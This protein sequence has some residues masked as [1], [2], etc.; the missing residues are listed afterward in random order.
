MSSAS[1][2]PTRGD[3]SSSSGPGTRSRS[4]V[5]RGGDKDKGS[6]RDRAALSLREL[7]M[8]GSQSTRASSV[9]GLAP[10]VSGDMPSNEML[11]DS[12]ELQ[13]ERATK[14]YTS[15]ME[16]YAKKDYA[17]ALD[18]FIR[19]LDFPFMKQA[20]VVMNVLQFVATPQIASQKEYINVIM[21]METEVRSEE[22]RVRNLL[23]T[24]SKALD[25][26]QKLIDVQTSLEGTVLM[27]STAASECSMQTS[28]DDGWSPRLMS[29]K[30]SI[31]GAALT[32]SSAQ[33]SELASMEKKIGGVAALT[34]MQA[35][36][37]FLILR[38]RGL[39]LGAW[40]KQIADEYSALWRD[41]LSPALRSSSSPRHN[42]LV[43]II[44]TCV[45]AL[46]I[47]VHSRLH[48]SSLHSLSMA[49]RVS[50][51]AGLGLSDS[52]LF[53]QAA[54]A[55]FLLATQPPLPTY[56]PSACDIH[57]T[58]LR[59]AIEAVPRTQPLQARTASDALETARELLELARG[60][61]GNHPGIIK[62]LLHVLVLCGDLVAARNL[63]SE[64]LRLEADVDSGRSYFASV[65]AARARA[66]LAKFSKSTSP[67][68]TPLSTEAQKELVILEDLLRR[69]QTKLKA[70]N[71][72]EDRGVEPWCDEA[73]FLTRDEH[74][75]TKLPRLWYVST[76][77]TPRMA[78]LVLS[79]HDVG[80]FSK[81]LQERS[82]TDES[83][84]PCVHA[85]STPRP[86]IIDDHALVDQLSPDQFDD[87]ECQPSEHIKARHCTLNECF[88][89]SG[90]SLIDLLMILHDLSNNAW[91]LQPS[92]P[93]HP[94]KRR[95]ANKPALS[96]QI[97]Q[98][99]RLAFERVELPYGLPSPLSVDQ[100]T[101]K[102]A[103]NHKRILWAARRS[104]TLG[105]TSTG[106]FP[107][108]CALGTSKQGKLR[109]RAHLAWLPLFTFA[110][111]SCLL[112]DDPESTEGVSMEDV[113][114]MADVN[115]QD[116][117]AQVHN[118]ED[119]ESGEAMQPDAAK[120][121]DLTT[122]E[123]SL[124]GA[125]AAMSRRSERR[126]VKIDVDTESSED[127]DGTDD[128]EAEEDAKAN[129]ST[130]ESLEAQIAKEIKSTFGHAYFG[131]L[132]SRLEDVTPNDTLPQWLGKL[133]A[134]AA[135]REHNSEQEGSHALLNES[136]AIDAIALD[137]SVDASTAA[138]TASVRDAEIQVP[139]LVCRD[140]Y[141]SQEVSLRVTLEGQNRDSVPNPVMGMTIMV[142]DSIPEHSIQQ[143]ASPT[144]PL[145]EFDAEVQSLLD[146]VHAAKE[147]VQT[148]FLMRHPLLGFP[149]VA[150]NQFL[151]APLGLTPQADPGPFARSLV[152]S[153]LHHRS[154]L[155]PTARY[156]DLGV[157]TYMMTAFKLPPSEGPTDSSNQSEV[158]APNSPGFAPLDTLGPMDSRGYV[159]LYGV[160]SAGLGFTFEAYQKLI[161]INDTTLTPGVANDLLE[162]G[163]DDI[164]CTA[165]Q[166]TSSQA[167][168]NSMIS[169]DWHA[170]DG[171]P[172]RLAIARSTHGD[173]AWSWSDVVRQSVAIV[174][175]RWL[176][177]LGQMGGVMNFYT[178]E[179]TTALQVLSGTLYPN[180]TDENA[181]AME[182]EV[183]PLFLPSSIIAAG[184]ALNAVLDIFL[185]G[186]QH[187]QLNLTEESSTEQSSLITCSDWAGFGV[188]DS[189]PSPPKAQSYAFINIW[190]AHAL[191]TLAIH[192]A[193]ASVTFKRM[194][195]AERR[196]ATELHGA[197]SNTREPGSVEPHGTLADPAI[198]SLQ[199]ALG[200]A[201]AYNRDMD[202]GPI[203]LS[204]NS[205]TVN[206]DQR[207]HETWRT[208]ATQCYNL[209]T[210][211]S[212]I[213]A[214]LK[215][216]AEFIPKQSKRAVDLLI[217]RLDSCVQL[218]ELPTMLSI[219]R[220]SC[221]D[222][223]NTVRSC[224]QKP[225]FSSWFEYLELMSSQ[226]GLKAENYLSREALRLT[227]GIVSDQLRSD[228]ET[229]IGARVV[230]SDGSRLQ[231][232]GSDDV[233][234]RF[235]KTL[236]MAVTKL[237]LD[238]QGI[239]DRYASHELQDQLVP[240]LQ[241]QCKELQAELDAWS[242]QKLL[243]HLLSTFETQMSA[244]D[245]TP[246]KTHF[247]ELLENAATIAK[248]ALPA[249]ARLQIRYGEDRVSLY[250]CESGTV[251]QSSYFIQLLRALELCSPG[252]ST[253]TDSAE[254]QVR[255]ESWESPNKFVSQAFYR[256][257]A[258][259]LMLFSDL[260]G[261]LAAL[262]ASELAAS[263]PQ[264]SLFIQSASPLYGFDPSAV[265]SA[266]QASLP[267]LALRAR[268]LAILM[269]LRDLNLA[270]DTCDSSRLRRYWSALSRAEELLKRLHQDAF[271]D[272]DLLGLNS[273]I[274]ELAKCHTQASTILH[275][276][277]SRECS[278]HDRLVSTLLAL[279]SDVSYLEGACAS[280]KQHQLSDRSQ[281]DKFWYRLIDLGLGA[282]AVLVTL[283]W[284][285]D[286]AILGYVVA[287]LKSLH[288]VYTQL[289]H[290]LRRSTP[291]SLERARD[292]IASSVF[293]DALKAAM[294][295]HRR[296]EHVANRLA[297]GV[298]SH[299]VQAIM[300]LRMA[301][302]KRLGGQNDVLQSWTRLWQPLIF[303]TTH[304]LFND[305]DYQYG[306]PFMLSRVRA[307]FI[308]TDHVAHLPFA[309][310][311]L[312][313][314]ID[315]V[316]HSMGDTLL[317]EVLERFLPRKL[318][319]QRAT[320]E[321]LEFVEECKQFMLTQPSLFSI[322]RMP[323]M[324]LSLPDAAYSYFADATCLMLTLMFDEHRQLRSN[325]PFSLI[326]DATFFLS[327]LVPRSGLA[328][329]F[330]LTIQRSAWMSKSLGPYPWTLHE[331]FPYVH[332]TQS[333]YL[334]A[335]ILRRTL[336]LLYGTC[337]E[338][339]PHELCDLLRGGLSDPQL[340]NMSIEDAMSR[341]EPTWDVSKCETVIDALQ[342][343]LHIK[344]GT[345][346]SF[347]KLLS[348]V[349]A[350]ACTESHCTWRA[351]GMSCY[352]AGCDHTDD[353]VTPP[354]LKLFLSEN[355]PEVIQSNPS[356]DDAA[357]HS[358][359]LNLFIHKRDAFQPYFDDSEY[360]ENVVLPC[361]LSEALGMS[362]TNCSEQE[363]LEPFFN[364][365]QYAHYGLDTQHVARF[366][367]QNCLAF[368]MGLFEERVDC[369]TESLTRSALYAVSPQVMGWISVLRDKRTEEFDECI[370]EH[371]PEAAPHT[372]GNDG[373]FPRGTFESVFQY[374]VTIM[375]NPA[376]PRLLK[377]FSEDLGDAI[378]SVFIPAFVKHAFEN[379]EGKS[380]AE[381]AL[382]PDVPELYACSDK[383]NEMSDVLRDSYEEDVISHRTYCRYFETLKDVL[384]GDGENMVRLF[385]RFPPDAKP[386]SLRN[387]LS[388]VS[389]LTTFEAL[390]QDYSRPYIAEIP[391]FDSVSPVGSG[392]A[393]KI[394]DGGFDLCSSLLTY[395]RSPEAENDVSGEIVSRSSIVWAQAHSLDHLIA[396]NYE[397]L[398]HIP[399]DD[400]GET[401]VRCGVFYA[402]S[403][404]PSLVSKR[405]LKLMQGTINVNVH[406]YRR[407][408]SFQ[409]EDQTENV[410]QRVQETVQRF[411]LNRTSSSPMTLRAIHQVLADLA[412]AEQQD[413]SLVQQERLRSLTSRLLYMSLTG[414]PQ[415]VPLRL[416]LP[417]SATRTAKHE[418]MFLVGAGLNSE[419]NP[420]ATIP[421]GF[422]NVIADMRDRVYQ[423]FTILSPSR[424]LVYAWDQ[425][426]LSPA[427]FVWPPTRVLNLLRMLIPETGTD[428]FASFQL[429][430]AAA[431]HMK[432]GFSSSFAP[433]LPGS[434]HVYLRK[435]ERDAGVEEIDKLEKNL[436]EIFSAAYRLEAR[437]MSHFPERTLFDLSLLVAQIA[438]VSSHVASVLSPLPRLS[439]T[440]TQLLSLQRLTRRSVKTSSPPIYLPAGFL[441]VHRPD[442]AQ[443]GSGRTPNALLNVITE[444]LTWPELTV[445]RAL[446]QTRDFGTAAVSIVP[447]FH[448]GDSL[449]P[450]HG[451][452]LNLA[453]AAL[454]K[455]AQDPNLDHSTNSGQ[456][457]KLPVL[458]ITS[459]QVVLR[460]IDATPSLTG[461]AAQGKPLEV[462]R[463]AIFSELW[464]LILQ[465]EELLKRQWYDPGKVKEATLKRVR[466]RAGYITSVATLLVPLT[467]LSRYL[468][469]LL[470]HADFL[471][472]VDTLED[473]D[474][475]ILL[476]YPF[477][478]DAPL[479]VHNPTNTQI[480]FEIMDFG[481]TNGLASEPFA[482]PA[483]RAL[484]TWQAA[485][486][487]LS[488]YI[489]ARDCYRASLLLSD[490]QTT[491]SYGLTDTALS[492]LKNRIIQNWSMLL[493]RARFLFTSTPE[494]CIPVYKPQREVMP[495]A[496][497]VSQPTD[498]LG[499][500]KAVVYVTE[501]REGALSLVESMSSED[502]TNLLTQLH[503][504][505]LASGAWNCQGASIRDLCA[506]PLGERLD[507][508]GPHPFKQF[509]A[510][511][512]E[513]L[514]DTGRMSI[515]SK[516]NVVPITLDAIKFVGH[517]I[518]NGWVGTDAAGASV[519]CPLGDF[520]QAISQQDL[521][522]LLVRDEALVTNESDSDLSSES[523]LHLKDSTAPTA[524]I[525]LL[526]A[527]AELELA[528]LV[529][530]RA[531]QTLEE[532]QW[533]FMQ[534][535]ARTIFGTSMSLGQ[536]LCSA[537]EALAEIR[538][539][540]NDTSRVHGFRNRINCATASFWQ[541]IQ[542]ALSLT[543][544]SLRI[545]LSEFYGSGPDLPSID[546][547]NAN[548]WLLNELIV[549]MQALGLG[550][551]SS[552]VCAMP[553]IDQLVRN[554]RASRGREQDI[555]RVRKICRGIF[556]GTVL[557]LEIRLWLMQMASRLTAAL[558]R[559]MSED[560]TDLP[561]MEVTSRATDII[562]GMRYGDLITEPSRPSGVPDSQVWTYPPLMMYGEYANLISTPG[563]AATEKERSVALITSSV[564][565]QEELEDRPDQTQIT[566]LPIYIQELVTSLTL[567]GTTIDAL[568]S[569]MLASNESPIKP[570]SLAFSKWIPRCSS[571]DPGDEVRFGSLLMIP[572]MHL[573]FARTLGQILA[574]TA[575]APH[576]GTTWIAC[577]KHVR[578]AA[579]RLLA[580][581]HGHALASL[582]YQQQLVMSQATGL[583]VFSN[584]LTNKSIEDQHQRAILAACGLLKD[585]W[586][587]GTM[588]QVKSE[589]ANLSPTETLPELSS[590]L[591][592]IDSSLKPFRGFVTNPS[593]KPA[594]HCAYGECANHFVMQVEKAAELMKSARQ[595]TQHVEAADAQ[596]LER[597]R[598]SVPS[599]M[600]LQTE[601]LINALLTVV[602][603]DIPKGGPTVDD[604]LKDLPYL[605]PA[606]A[607][608]K[609]SHNILWATQVLFDLIQAWMH[610]GLLGTSLG[611]LKDC[612]WP[613]FAP[614]KAKRTLFAVRSN[615]SP[616]ILRFIEMRAAMFIRGC[617]SLLRCLRDQ[618]DFAAIYEQVAPE[619]AVEVTRD[620][621]APHSAQAQ[622][623]DPPSTGD[624]VQQPDSALMQDTS[625]DPPP[626]K[627]RPQLVRIEPC[628]IA[629][630]LDPEGESIAAW[631]SVL[632]FDAVGC[633]LIREEA[634]QKSIMED[635][636]DA[637]KKL[638]KRIKKLSAQRLRRMGEK[639]PRKTGQTQLSDEASIWG[640]DSL[641][642]SKYPGPGLA[643]SEHL[644]HQQ[645]VDTLGTRP[646]FRERFQLRS[647]SGPRTS[648]LLPMSVNSRFQ[649]AHW[650]PH[651]LQ[652]VL[653]VRA[654]SLL[655]QV[656]MHVQGPDCGSCLAEHESTI[657]NSEAQSTEQELVVTD[658]DPPKTALRNVLEQ[659][660]DQYLALTQDLRLFESKHTIWRRIYQ[661]LP[662]YGTTCVNE[663]K[664]S[665]EPNSVSTDRMD[666]IQPTHLTPLTSPVP[667]ATISD[668]ESVDTRAD[669]DEG[670][671]AASATKPDEAESGVQLG[672]RRRRRPMKKDEDASD[673]RK[674]VCIANMPV[675]DLS[676]E[677]G[678]QPLDAE[679]GA[680][681]EQALS[682]SCVPPVVSL[683]IEIA[684][685]AC[686]IDWL[687]N[688]WR[689]SS[690]GGVQH[691]FDDE[692]R[693]RLV[694][695]VLVPLLQSLNMSAIEFLP[696]PD[697]LKELYLERCDS[698]DE[699]II[700]EEVLAL[701]PI[702]QLTFVGSLLNAKQPRS[703]KEMVRLLV[704]C[705][706]TT[707]RTSPS[708]TDLTEITSQNSLRMTLRDVC[709]ATGTYLKSNLSPSFNTG[710][711]ILT[712]ILARI[713]SDSDEQ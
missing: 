265:P 408:R 52:T 190:A 341:L 126:S 365:T 449:V 650:L 667:N 516:Y 668:E 658:S 41:V 378:K 65:S 489:S 304:L 381:F 158:V 148:H 412:H 313:K 379:T 321:T 337:V 292:V 114:V 266:C 223:P 651:L 586:A 136:E 393:A 687:A 396:I 619:E 171:S 260:M 235:V 63:A 325:S 593:T 403:A 369:D 21:A 352:L 271:H 697:A 94:R 541:L 526:D 115:G 272:I 422:S 575:G 649:V 662:I 375:D 659:S 285:G 674:R 655:A 373:N 122:A 466:K 317:D 243:G 299:I 90:V 646:D 488:R 561:P 343:L 546:I 194:I 533:V 391:R 577:S 60:I 535:Q 621:T 351:E 440:T 128:N 89:G 36:L 413:V 207:T 139:F 270:V 68:R 627:A 251:T 600:V 307:D 176:E 305:Y 245:F 584:D 637:R 244:E 62:M 404:I 316:G 81:F 361:G 267:R 77:H 287:R 571:D 681:N 30:S 239:A 594:L 45:Q 450:V 463:Q 355:F 362:L 33:A 95:S 349:P 363:V 423:K 401:Y 178:S 465:M 44:L 620:S 479:Q 709:L 435:L 61:D 229:T 130:G 169:I 519:A 146:P 205:P 661:W 84:R 159:H 366:V 468:L 609:N 703:L 208:L 487:L 425:P 690:A 109:K 174:A 360:S 354:R 196:Q 100:S 291:S 452:R 591:D 376:E 42:M 480:L 135:F 143:L 503:A 133:F 118:A 673:V 565:H 215:K 464:D 230:A 595:G 441:D 309:A 134:P 161:L 511:G 553:N 590:I 221:L 444:A 536:S 295:K 601:E 707:P 699:R 589:A 680:Y 675:I 368:R 206:A 154:S 695:Y 103:W 542:R 26:V 249:L 654:L 234:E 323:G 294:P 443:Y 608:W 263:Q 491:K 195:L 523:A 155:M 657:A 10:G 124:G 562:V 105:L 247:G 485:T 545:L 474:S 648:V 6:G 240:T 686:T 12:T 259:V 628:E 682:E 47:D 66:V 671:I 144:Q 592:E 46:L 200:D 567:T 238:V 28:V 86:R 191:R 377:N 407:P 331:V 131:K 67:S 132:K 371:A 189:L 275:N 706:T 192:I 39:V 172:L 197:P 201:F 5:Q 394:A 558:A 446:Q 626:Q 693:L 101:A 85:Q 358:L 326:R 254:M 642:P 110:G 617:A 298:L 382:L 96:L 672:Q 212:Y 611:P 106:L 529:W 525:P 237:T 327:L 43:R 29:R 504:L 711:K 256:M 184:L 233:A 500:E 289:Y 712:S 311:F 182:V 398:S 570:G 202:I 696:I 23:D 663:R 80:P 598:Y 390:L 219:Q 689:T 473:P 17:V 276:L 576:S 684:R 566:V 645:L 397:A 107:I 185:Q 225:W 456:G 79:P 470:A 199:S 217:A 228:T 277:I 664:L 177:D 605:S 632:L 181:K 530:G 478:G 40:A 162:A 439:A 640:M 692:S 188:L 710:A 556:A 498:E 585:A 324:R 92:S 560:W 204:L 616:V 606:E 636:N 334:S 428:K 451:L 676:E 386:P 419:V 167:E 421:R 153:A 374:V 447:L 123:E 574:L 534:E 506:I 119:G 180:D 102:L 494:L 683:Q 656:A 455:L 427:S 336:K 384:Y 255:V 78:Y 72:V 623:T 2:D 634:R 653:S 569:H 353:A 669:E 395:Q 596:V 385:Y 55:A 116:S 434:V 517:S 549:E 57:L 660:K 198:A 416:S 49:I 430:F 93:T 164:S 551:A 472:L 282:S 142:E 58:T 64:I 16:A 91:I 538:A 547:A 165:Q 540:A 216:L 417:T 11:A 193:H 678:E 214:R 187:H 279:R 141:P 35:R 372:L 210:S 4:P 34:N 457:F 344:T 342:L 83:E 314:Q 120:I 688:Q 476:R 32:T 300:R 163:V 329:Y 330:P 241:N 409:T 410:L 454:C 679:P 402:P 405:A 572:S 477:L 318:M 312:L 211:A 264:L 550:M 320:G 426:R 76:V 564:L 147:L 635:E 505:G 548:P 121:V 483:L 302:V 274:S 581:V 631:A 515:L 310:K 387:A 633:L 467:P 246:S 622:L 484:V 579:E 418:A 283:I 587:I 544:R 151:V 399:L 48:E 315:T 183:R 82:S 98:S 702:T 129:Q 588:I 278:D 54:S 512:C 71:S 453:L 490:V 269:R 322:L 226:D 493:I 9:P 539:Q 261:F 281:D 168:T 638:D 528:H 400:Q 624:E 222:S 104:Q 308:L 436:F 99:C 641:N 338:R 607:S 14:L 53:F 445:Y 513:N 25:F 514:S 471:R 604:A 524:G 319:Y 438:A 236:Q 75:S 625:T 297:G 486:P 350:L 3:G 700:L 31:G 303:H 573:D 97:L 27:E 20:D 502:Q 521:A 475:G 420:G 175:S 37:L 346:G 220:S 364:N 543:L 383:I 227:Y 248:I 280:M 392:F 460:L 242:D 708:S 345:P 224:N 145:Y 88:Q 293:T 522:S 597:I 19:A 499:F 253:T 647:G 333:A 458:V 629:R 411:W 481:R 173:Q 531:T 335:V 602:Q 213:L 527:A 284:R 599:W 559:T 108:I 701:K 520:G 262:P 563:Q 414:S 509:W 469:A 389:E 13:T 347:V 156:G 7:S 268:I 433:V 388:R 492:G 432:A 218:L 258:R 618:L 138:I 24:W 74:M 150:R 713:T 652:A 140:S 555:A 495:S 113:A 231:P 705:P 643:I 111:S 665:E 614:T 580:H 59:Q 429:G 613:L 532:S 152:A 612:I 252:I 448:L 209:V 18:A 179:T 610:P 170:S 603:S 288:I 497:R 56:W 157:N 125:K 340:A 670:S 332:A 630:H 694:N 704:S 339:S 691:G 15:G 380:S 70:Q 127:S 459:E 367:S 38:N 501:L 112:E 644:Y 257:I 87:V 554:A 583:P 482:A 203:I 117:P 508:I 406:R 518:Q 415:S 582:A 552:H 306:V 442:T 698:V 290:S 51:G 677:L 666:V 462:L 615:D 685:L 250:I 22:A 273:M 578:R 8:L 348:S 50:S 232:K 359:A 286:L 510:I 149:L 639:M 568:Y 160:V 69:Q 296:H 73:S 461:P 1:S 557:L 496:E 370:K 437:M 424:A 166:G 186:V 507:G 537:V 328:P 137:D 301:R 356:T 431:E 357:V